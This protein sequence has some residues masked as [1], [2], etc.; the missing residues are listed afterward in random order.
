M[1]T[2]EKEEQ[3]GVLQFLMS[4]NRLLQITDSSKVAPPMPPTEGRFDV[5][6]DND[7]IRRLDLSSFQKTTGII[8][9]LSSKFV[10]VLVCL[11]LYHCFEV[12]SVIPD[13]LSFLVL[14]QLNQNNFLSV[15]LVLP[16][17]IPEKI[18]TI[19]ESYRNI[20]T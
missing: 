7:T 17:I 1:E 5:I 19:D 12:S 20:L 15:R 16:S 4:F 10:G 9:P 11:S 8:S 6:I 3:L 14:V 2:M 18:L 13:E